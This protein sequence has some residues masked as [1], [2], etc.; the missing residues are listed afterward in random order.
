MA[1]KRI[2]KKKG[3][4]KSNKKSKNPKSNYSLEVDKEEERLLRCMSTKSST[5]NADE[6]TSLNGVDATVQRKM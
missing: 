3:G 6:K 1:K 4:T 2:N 5:V